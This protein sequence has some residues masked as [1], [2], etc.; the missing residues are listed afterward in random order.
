MSSSESSPK[1]TILPSS[2]E[3]LVSSSAVLSSLPT[4]LDSLPTNAAE[5]PVKSS[6]S[7]A[8]SPNESCPIGALVRS[9]RS[10]SSNSSF[11]HLDDCDV[12]FD[13]AVSNHEYWSMASNRI[14]DRPQKISCCL[15]G[16]EASSAPTIWPIG[17]DEITWCKTNRGNERMCMAGHTYDF[18]SLSI[19]NNR[20]TFRC[21]KKNHGCRSV[22]YVS[23]DSKMYKDCNHIDH[24]HR[25]NYCH[26]KRLV[27]L[28]QVKQRV[29]TE[30]TSITRIIEDEYAKS[31]LN[32]DERR[33]FL[34]P[35]SQGK[36][37]RD[38][39]YDEQ[40]SMFTL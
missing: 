17:I 5:L 13:N 31:N 8:S 27:V 32:D 15:D 11:D 23:M 19:K 24:N 1:N 7:P 18:M 40:V 6:L 14:D 39:D 20:K 28:D 2:S 30:P 37:S 29:S 25:P 12:T 10:S 36:R 3:N 9:S 16:E 26:V 34:L 38:S 22:V 4:N 35:T 33:Q 21:S